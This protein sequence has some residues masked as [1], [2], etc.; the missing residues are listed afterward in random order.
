MRHAKKICGIL[1]LLGASVYATAQNVGIGTTDPKARLH[2]AD[3]AV[4]FSTSTT[5]TIAP[6]PN[7]PMEGP[8]HRMMWYPAKAAFRA[9]SA[10]FEWDKDNI[11][12]FSAAFGVQNT[13]SG[14]YSF[15][16]GYLNRSTNTGSFS[17]GIGSTASGYASTSFGESTTA[18]GFISTT[19]GYQT[20]AT[21]S[22][23]F[24]F[25][26]RSISRGNASIA[27]GEFTVAKARGGVS[28]GSYN[29][30]TDNPT[31]NVYNNNDRIFQVGNGTEFVRRNAFT[32]LRN[33][34][35]GIGELNPEFTLDVNGRMRLQSNNSLSAGINLNNSSN[36]SIA[37]FVGMRSTDNE[38]GF[39][40]QT[41]TIGWRY[42]VNTTT[43]DAWLQGSLTQNSDIRLKKNIKPLSNTLNAIQQLKGYSYQWKDPSNPDEQIGLLAQEIQKVYPQLVKENVNGDLS[44]NYNGMIPILLEAI[45]ELQQKVTELENKL[46]Q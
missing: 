18:S 19:M 34:N 45:K 10:F 31:A 43:G 26:D 13:A 3:S 12:N 15:S 16:S 32:V 22:I 39:Y 27:M 8:G 42:L 25:G 21:G 2:V 30:S 14:M 11:G 35:T 36:S 17:M 37:A 40:G 20:R 33:G 7:P 1:L 6:Y 4:L 5:G 46:K 24:S 44:V 41:G 9:G 23:S 29:D 28:L 38:V